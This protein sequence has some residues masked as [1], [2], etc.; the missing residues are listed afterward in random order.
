MYEGWYDLCIIPYNSYNGLN[1]TSRPRLRPECLPL[2]QSQERRPVRISCILPNCI[3][4]PIQIDPT[5][6]EL[7]HKKNE[8]RAHNH[9]RVQSGREDVVVLHP[10]MEVSSAQEE[11]E[12]ESGD[13]PRGIVNPCGR[14]YSCNPSK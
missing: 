12:D 8:N 3:P 5:F 13:T 7:Q 4:P 14:R 10:P 11:V 9:S 1:T 2:T 6:G